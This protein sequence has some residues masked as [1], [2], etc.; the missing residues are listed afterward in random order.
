M[1]TTK[2]PPLRRCVVRGFSMPAADG[3][4]NCGRRGRFMK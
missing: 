1:I 3:G 2:L 4:L